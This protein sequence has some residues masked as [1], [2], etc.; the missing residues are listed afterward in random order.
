MTENYGSENWIS[1]I[2]LTEK[3]VNRLGLLSSLN[4]EIDK[5]LNQ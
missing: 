3:S 2:D 5:R 1:L 4:L